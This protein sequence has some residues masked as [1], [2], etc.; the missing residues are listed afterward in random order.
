MWAEYIVG[1]NLL[2]LACLII[3]LGLMIA[4]M[5]TPG[6]GLP[7]LLGAIALIAAIVLSAR[8]FTAALITLALILIILGICAFFFF[9]L[10]NRG[11]LEN[12]WFV[13]KDAINAQSTGDAQQSE[14]LI[15]LEGVCVNA[16]RP[17]GHADFGSKRLD[18]IT[19]GAFIERGSAVRI[20]RVEGF[21]IIVRKI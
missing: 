4:E 8:S 7:A 20:E 3:G 13:L 1:W 10:V 6:L 2:A 9:R 18:V 11:K 15:G 5:F 17:A 16:L 12:S 19:E 21:K 14:S